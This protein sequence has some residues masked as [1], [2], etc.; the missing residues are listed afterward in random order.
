MSREGTGQFLVPPSTGRETGGFR[1]MKK[2]LR[3]GS[4][5]IKKRLTKK[6]FQQGGNGYRDPSWN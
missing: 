4:R 3:M 6:D 2:K 5:F 1:G